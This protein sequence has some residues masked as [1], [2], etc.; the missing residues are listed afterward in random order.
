MNNASVYEQLESEKNVSATE[1]ED[2]LLSR[3][4]LEEKEKEKENDD[5]VYLVGSAQE[6]EKMATEGDKK[7]FV[8]LGSLFNRKVYRCYKQTLASGEYVYDVLK[9]KT[10]KMIIE[11]I[12]EQGFFP[13]KQDGRQIY[14]PELVARVLCLFPHMSYKDLHVESAIPVDT[15]KS[16]KKRYKQY[17]SAREGAVPAKRTF[18]YEVKEF[19]D[20]MPS[21]GRLTLEMVKGVIEE[22][23]LKRAPYVSRGKKSQS[24]AAVYVAH[25]C[26]LLEKFP[27]PY[28]IGNLVH[29]PGQI[30]SRW[31]HYVEN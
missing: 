31:V 9:E 17:I 3:D 22:Y 13:S 26:R 6:E 21:H 14:S 5:V 24:Y 29:V 1:N 27:H 15:L 11:E 8:N 25:I 2:F 4:V 12:R 28:V 18:R 19:Y 10:P 23:R 20:K 30:I 7:C 16:W